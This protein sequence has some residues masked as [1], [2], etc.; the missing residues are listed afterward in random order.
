MSFVLARER[1]TRAVLSRKVPRKSTGDWTCRRL[2]GWRREIGLEFVDMD[3]E[4]RQ[5][6]SADE[7]D[8]VAEHA[9]SN[10]KWIEDDQLEQSCWMFKV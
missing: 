10:E 7:F 5:R 3:R 8:R 9:E 2:M 1:V 6:A 4:V